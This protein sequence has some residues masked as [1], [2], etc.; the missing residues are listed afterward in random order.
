VETDAEAKERTAQKVW[1]D[2]RGRGEGGRTSAHFKDYTGVCERDGA[3]Y[4]LS[5]VRMYL[6]D[7]HA[8]TGTNGHEGRQFLPGY[9]IKISAEKHKKTKTNT[10]TNTNTKTRRRAR[11]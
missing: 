7:T 10:N 1:R 9:P 8:H 5:R 11:R 3:I 4:C 6:Q 2:M